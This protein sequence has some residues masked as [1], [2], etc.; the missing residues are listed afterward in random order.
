MFQTKNSNN[1]IKVSDRPPKKQISL[2]LDEL[3]IKQQRHS[4]IF[5]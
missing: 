3:A 5:P 1:S 2:R 4:P